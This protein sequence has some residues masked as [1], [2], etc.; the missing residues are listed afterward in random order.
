MVYKVFVTQIKKKPF[1]KEENLG[2]SMLCE[3]FA[4]LEKAAEAGRKHLLFPASSFE[5]KEYDDSQPVILFGKGDAGRV[6]YRATKEHN[7]KFC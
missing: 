5:V 1:G 4:S 6:I 2:T 7:V 3:T